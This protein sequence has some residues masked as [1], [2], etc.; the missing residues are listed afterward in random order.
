MC[1]TLPKLLREMNLACEVQSG[2]LGLERTVGH[3]R[4]SQDGFTRLG[5]IKVLA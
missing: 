4:D 5:N 3:A 2:T 1:E